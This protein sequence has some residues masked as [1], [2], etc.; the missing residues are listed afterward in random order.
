MEIPRYV[1]IVVC[2]IYVSLTV[3]HRTDGQTD[4][5]TDHLNT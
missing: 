3:K 1:D 2:E 4:S 5:R